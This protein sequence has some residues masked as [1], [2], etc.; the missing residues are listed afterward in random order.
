MLIA[1]DYDPIGNGRQIEIAV[2]SILA[3]YIAANSENGSIAAA[4]FQQ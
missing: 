2:A 1:S 3:A 4:N